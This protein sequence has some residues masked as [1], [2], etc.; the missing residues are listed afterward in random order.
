VFGLFQRFDFRCRRNEEKYEQKH[1]RK[2]RRKKEKE[3]E[4]KE[5]KEGKKERRKETKERKRK[6]EQKR[7]E[8]LKMERSL[9]ETVFISGRLSGS[10]VRPE[11]ISSASEEAH[12]C[13]FISL[14]SDNSAGGS[15]STTTREIISASS[16]PS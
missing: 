3:A 6:R 11:V 15:L 14:N 1:T 2:R 7:N 10:R 8:P 16:N 13:S 9:V 5:R 12:E 4:E